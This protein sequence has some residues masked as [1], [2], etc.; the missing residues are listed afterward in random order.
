MEC[1]ATGPRDRVDHA[2]GSEA[3]FRRVAVGQHRKLLN[4]VYAGVSAEYAS[5]TRVG[6]VV[7]DHAVEPVDVLL[8]PSSVNGHLYSEPARRATRCRHL[9]VRPHR[10]YARVQCSQGGPVASIQRQLYDLCAF[11]LATE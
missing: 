7:D 3:V 2:T 4:R 5:R 10:G 9:F 11:D 8:G 1:I 6:V